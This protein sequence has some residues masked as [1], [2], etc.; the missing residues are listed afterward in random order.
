MR[1]DG[2][3]ARRDLVQ[4]LLAEIEALRNHPVSALEAGHDGDDVVGKDGDDIDASG[5][6]LGRESAGE[7]VD[8]GLGGGVHR[9]HGNGD[10][11]S[12]GREVDDEGLA[13]GEEGD[14]GLGEVS[15]E[16][17]VDVEHGVDLIIGGL[18][19]VGGESSVDADVVNKDG[20]IEILD[21]IDNRLDSGLTRAVNGDDLSLNL[22]LG[23]ELLRN[24]LK[25]LLITGNKNNVETAGSK[26]HGITLADTLTGTSDHSPST[27]LGA[28][29]GEIRLEKEVII[30]KF[31]NDKEEIS[32][33][34]D[35]DPGECGHVAS[36]RKKEGNESEGSLRNS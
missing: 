29:L 2:V 5:V 21:L 4:G 23:L 32:N 16:D 6:E 19:K 20:D 35:A 36:I 27:L 30:N 24:G 25:T 26:S 33:G 14:H 10:L 11:A 31:A 34:K 17:D 18:D 7:G 22:E 12:E 28:I 13:L 9:H 15:G 3:V 1:R 8:V